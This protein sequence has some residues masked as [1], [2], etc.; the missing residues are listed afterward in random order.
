MQY[1]FEIR[2]ELHDKELTSIVE[3]GPDGLE[4]SSELIVEAKI[5]VNTELPDKA[6]EA[7]RKAVS[8]VF[9]RKLGVK[10]EAKLLSS[11]H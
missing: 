9:S 6:V 2:A 10:A 4:A 3:A 1:N 7:L 11:E 8:S 5:R